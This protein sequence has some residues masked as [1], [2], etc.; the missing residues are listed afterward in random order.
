MAGSYK[1]RLIFFIFFALVF[2]FV[3]PFLILYATGYSFDFKEKIGL[4]SRGGI[5]VYVSEPNASVYI[6]NDLKKTTGFFSREVVVK[7]LKP[8]E[9]LVLVSHNDYWPWAKSVNVNKGEVTPLYPLLIPK[10]LNETELKAPSAEYS[11]AIALF[12]P[13]PKE[14]SSTLD[15]ILT[16]R[17]T[18]VW[19]EE[20]LVFAQWLSNPAA[21]PAYFCRTGDCTHSN[22][23]F[24]P[25]MKIKRFD[26]YPDR[27]D[28]IIL[29]LDDGIYVTELDNRQYQN[30][31]PI[32]LGKEP[33]FRVRNNTVYV[34][35][36]DFLAKIDL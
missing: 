13:D 16:S 5:Y 18:K 3:M 12:R 2:V 11:Q 22:V 10:V 4:I 24:S 1:K 20:N 35:D 21:A 7:S 29:T 8:Q 17:R 25:T 31:Y 6:G 14:A 23:L 34:R 15:V 26:F 19:V 9:Y 28:A 36:G 30:V 27:D 33:D 32:Y